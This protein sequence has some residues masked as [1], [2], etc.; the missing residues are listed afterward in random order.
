MTV[1]AA[2]H[3]PPPPPQPDTRIVTLQMPYDVAVTLVRVF[4]VI[5]GN[6]HTTYRVHGEEIKQALYAVGVEGVVG[7]RFSGSLIADPLPR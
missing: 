4:M 6:P 2:I 1:T 3:T 7:T 5:G